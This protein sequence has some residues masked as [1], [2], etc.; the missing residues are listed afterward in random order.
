MANK[1][2]QRRRFWFRCFRQL[3]KLRYKRPKYIYL[4]EKPTT[5]SIVLSNH[6]GAT[7]PILFETYAEFPMRMWGTYE[8]NSGFRNMKGR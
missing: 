5:N 3:F 2:R 7:V 4:G 1:V 8:M 6:V